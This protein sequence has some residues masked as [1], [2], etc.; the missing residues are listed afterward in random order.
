MVKP[1]RRNRTNTSSIA[2][3]G[4]SSYSLERECQSVT[5]LNKPA[6]LLVPHTHTP[7]SSLLN[8]PP[9]NT[10]SH[11]CIPNKIKP[12]MS[13]SAPAHAYTTPK[14]IFIEIIQTI[15]PYL[16]H[17]RFVFTSSHPI[18]RALYIQIDLRPY[19]KGYQSTRGADW[20]LSHFPSR[21]H[22]SVPLPYTLA[23][24]DFLLFILYTNIFDIV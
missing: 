11:V 24:L 23:E 6:G 12:F 21:S 15:G 22:S 16:A 3:M 1:F 5:N 19:Q 17:F 14:S 2:L 20:L 18:I 4:Y 10:E 13:Y 8:A 7:I 9:T